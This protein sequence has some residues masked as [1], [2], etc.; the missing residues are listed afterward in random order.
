MNYLLDTHTLLWSLTDKEK[1]SD[2]AF[3]TIEDPANAIYVSAITFWEISLKFSIGKLNLDGIT[4]A[5]LPELS[6]KTGFQHLSLT[7][8]ES[9]TY[10]Y[11]KTTNHKDPFDRM[12][13]WQAMQQNLIFISKD[14]RLAQYKSEGLKTLW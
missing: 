14:E 4:P 3:H 12:L 9:S 2:K 8:E 5:K 1:L 11:L 10:N 13:I 7:P 6:L